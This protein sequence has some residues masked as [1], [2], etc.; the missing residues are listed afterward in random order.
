LWR[1]L[2][3]DAS[4]GGDGGLVDVWIGRF[5]AH[6]WVNSNLPTLSDLRLPL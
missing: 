4:K 1:F 3:A 6:F 5:L 2:Q